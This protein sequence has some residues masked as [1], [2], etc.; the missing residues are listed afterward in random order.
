MQGDDVRCTAREE[1]TGC[2][3]RCVS[4]DYCSGQHRKQ[5]LYHHAPDP[6]RP[7]QIWPG[8]ARP[9]QAKPGQPPRMTKFDDIQALFERVSEKKKKLAPGNWTPYVP[10]SQ[11]WRLSIAVFANNLI[12]R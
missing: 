7:D 1:T 6:T 5:L 10:G 3:A 4:D 11:I 9:G 12:C 8:Q 2:P